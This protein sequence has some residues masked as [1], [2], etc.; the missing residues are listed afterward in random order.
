[1]VPVEKDYV[2]E[3]PKG[4]ARLLDL[5]ERRLVDALLEAAIEA[6]H[7]VGCGVL[8]HLPEADRQAGRAG[9]EESE[10]ASRCRPEP[11]RGRLQADERIVHQYLT[12]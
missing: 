10:P 2:F 5:F 3:G 8:R 11:E 9:V 1:M 7:E 6:D 4:P 12:V